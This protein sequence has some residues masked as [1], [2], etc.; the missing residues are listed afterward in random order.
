MSDPRS[1]PHF[2][3]TALDQLSGA[4]RNSKEFGATGQLKSMDPRRA[5]AFAATPRSAGKR[6]AIQLRAGDFRVSTQS[7]HPNMVFAY[8]NPGVRFGDRTRSTSRPISKDG[9]TSFHFS[10]SYMSK[11]SPIHNLI[12]EFNGG[13]AHSNSKAGDHLEYIERDGAAEELGRRKRYDG[14]DIFLDNFD[15]IEDMVAKRSSQEQQDYLERAGAAEK[16][17]LRNIRDDE[18]DALR[19]AS[20]GTIG[21][22]IEERHHFWREVEKLEADPRGDKVQLLINGDQAIWRLA[23]ANLKSAPEPLRKALETRAAGPVPEVLTLDKVPTPK[24]F[25][26]YKWV[27]GIDQNFSI[28]IEPGRGGRVQN[29]IIAELPHELDPHERITIV[30]DFTNKL[31]EKGLPFWAVIHA[32]DENNDRRN[33]HVHIVYYDRPAAKMPDPQSPMKLIWDFEPTATIKYG[34]RNTRLVRPFAQ[35]KLREASDQKWIKDLRTHWEKVSNAALEEAGL[36]K[37][38]DARTYKEMGISLEP[39]KHIPSKTFNKERKGELTPDGVSLAR[40]QWDVILEN[41]VSEN[42][43][44]TALRRR[45]VTRN[46]ERVERLI[47]RMNPNK[48]LAIREVQRIAKI[49]DKYAVLLGM[50]ELCQDIT[51]VVIDRVAS[52][53]KLVFHSAFGDTG[54]KPRGRPR[55]NPLPIASAKHLPSDAEEARLFL[56]TIIPE[57]QRLDRRN[58]EE[59]NQVRGHLALLSR[60]LE[61]FEKNPTAHPR[62]RREPAYVDLDK[63]DPTPAEIARRREEA[64]QRVQESMAALAQRNLS[65]ALKAALNEAA[66]PSAPQTHAPVPEP[67]PEAPPTEQKPA[68]AST[69]SAPATGPGSRPAYL[70]EKNPK[71]TRF[72]YEP[73]SY[74]PDRPQKTNSHRGTGFNTTVT[75][76]PDATPLSPPEARQASGGAVPAPPAA[77]KQ[78]RSASNPQES[79]VASQTK[80]IPVDPAPTPARVMPDSKPLVAPTSGINVPT[81]RQEP[82]AAKDVANSKEPST[83]MPAVPSQAAAE[84]AGGEPRWSVTLTQKPVLPA[85]LIQGMMMQGTEPE[86]VKILDSGLESGRYVATSPTE[87]GDQRKGLAANADQAP[88]QS[89][90][91]PKPLQGRKG[92]KKGFSRDDGYER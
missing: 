77:P 88:I 66:P 71:G 35:N 17:E 92:R 81:Q 5:G 34:S 56:K 60:R 8:D 6:N 85:R 36:K 14:M 62:D 46:A 67:K 19:T 51:R 65:E 53:A 20:F 80:S 70:D 48:A 90:L 23:L 86:R 2:T 76:T 74:R 18:I 91:P 22:T 1:P 64:I 24:A 42:F 7:A 39:L 43:R 54:K 41:V 50:A 29:R 63:F 49:A 12:R 33:Y 68:P 10:H 25:A 57:G 31:T 45:N 55:K 30:R 32:P 69:P 13:R 4:I 15:A 75:Q 21:A 16:L 59:L 87:K 28:E 84:R 38:Y 79:T 47:T 37:R 26:I 72:R 58:R 83:A 82:T 52:R 9:A 44:S 27:Y 61:Q 73:F 40:R 11:T 3:V 89:D 78:A